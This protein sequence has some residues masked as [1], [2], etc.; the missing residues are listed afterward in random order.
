MARKQ[1]IT[2][3]HRRKKERKKIALKSYSSPL[4]AIT[5]P[6]EKLTYTEM[7]RRM[8]KRT[9]HSGNRASIGSARG[10]E[11]YTG[12]IRKKVKSNEQGPTQEAIAIYSSIQPHDLRTP[13]PTFLT[14]AQIYRLESSRGLALPSDHE[15]SPVPLAPTLA[16]SV[17]QTRPQIPEAPKPNRTTRPS[18]KTS[19]RNLKE[20]AT[21]PSRSS[22]MSRAAGASL[23]NA[24]LSRR[25]ARSKSKGTT[26]EA[27]LASP[28]T[29]QFTSP[30]LS[31][32]RKSNQKLSALQDTTARPTRA[33]SDT[34]FNPNLPSHRAHS[35]PQAQ[36]TANSPVRRPFQDDSIKVR[37]PSA[38]SGSAQRPDVGS[39]FVSL[40][41][42]TKTDV[43]DNQI[44]S[45]P[46]FDFCGIQSRATPVDFNRPPSQ[47]SYSST[48]DEAFFGDA[49]MI[50]TPFGKKVHR[51]GNVVF[52]ESPDSTDEE[53]GNRHSTSRNLYPSPIRS[54][55]QVSLGPDILG[56]WMSDSLISPP[57]LSHGAYTRQN[58]LDKDFD[59]DFLDQADDN[60]SDK[61]DSLGLGL[62][63]KI[64]PNCDLATHLHEYEVGR[65]QE[66]ERPETLQELFNSLDLGSRNGTSRLPLSRTHSLDYEQGRPQEGKPLQSPAQISPSKLK[67]STTD[68]A[69]VKRGGRERRGTIRASDFP[70]L[71]GSSTTLLGGGPRRTRSG[72]IVQGPSHPRRERSNT[73]LARPPAI[74]TSITA[75]RRLDDGDVDMG[76]VRE[77]DDQREV[78][79]VL[80]SGDE[81]E[82][83]LLLKG[84]W[85]DEDWA[86]AEPPSPELPRRST[87]KG[88]G[89]H[90]WKKRLRLRKGLGSWGREEH[91]EDVGEDDP[92]L[93]T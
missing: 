35:R 20:N 71:Q 37:R 85:C 13:H 43:Y 88:K 67:N 57:T 74:I 4:Q 41:P 90:D 69:K 61:E 15:F 76:H 33:L 22:S 93:L 10:P 23:G 63:V 2:Y 87:R 86:V 26:Q 28:F 34:H 7:T 29:S 60:D 21:P 44:L 91:D 46:T 65:V 39:W 42:A 24:A 92:L 11:E 6:E 48:Y 8:L 3:A 1:V 83:E 32:R 38:P 50:S 27:P 62:A 59:M 19:S 72:T 75:V 66:D 52:Q 54:A 49:L 68:A 73:I 78:D 9:R 77:E 18:H 79:D 36:S 14:E 53:D 64:H 89:V 31:P 45:P 30:H 56:P 58:S 47:L 25:D 17:L 51:A 40:N 12:H 5:D 80:M 70:V 82:D 55:L 16:F 84:Q 81:I